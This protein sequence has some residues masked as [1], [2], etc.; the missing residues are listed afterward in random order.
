[1]N[2][3]FSKLRILILDRSLRKRV[4]FVVGIFFLFRLLAVIPIPG[5]DPSGLSRLLDSN[6]LLGLFNVIS[7]GGLS[8]LSIVMLGVSPYITASIIMQVLSLM[9]PSIKELMQG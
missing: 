8:S 4:L 5:V 7:G 9:S 6:Q 1:M 2:S 3:F